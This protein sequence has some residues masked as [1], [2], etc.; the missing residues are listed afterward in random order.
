M[1]DDCPA[2]WV[3]FEGRQ[4][5]F[6][7][8][9]VTPPLS[10]VEIDITSAGKQPTDEIKVQTDDQGKYRQVVCP[11][12]NFKQDININCNCGYDTIFQVKDHRKKQLGEL[13]HVDVVVV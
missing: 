3:E 9:Q 1:L 2:S 7:E 5:V 6:L 4:G 12:F 10:G 13:V 8:G 11:G